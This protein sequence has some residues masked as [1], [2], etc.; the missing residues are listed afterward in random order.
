M[1]ETLYKGIVKFYKEFGMGII[2]LP[3]AMNPGPRGKMEEMV[4]EGIL[5]KVY[6]KGTQH[7]HYVLND[8][9]LYIYEDDE[10]PH[11]IEFIRYFIN[12]D[13]PEL[14][15]ALSKKLEEEVGGSIRE[16]FEENL[17]EEYNQWYETNKVKLENFKKL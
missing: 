11:A 5:R 9:N 15:G 3:A 14:F 6:V 13:D 8:P 17:M 7:T 1:D 2:D 4:E 10:N 16:W 12:P